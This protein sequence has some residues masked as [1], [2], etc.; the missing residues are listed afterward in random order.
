VV[1]FPDRFSSD[2]IVSTSGVT[3]LWR[4]LKS[5]PRC[6]ISILAIDNF[7]RS[8]THAFLFPAQTS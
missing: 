6:P 8:L 3:F 5:A 7:S 2:G 4:M 1:A